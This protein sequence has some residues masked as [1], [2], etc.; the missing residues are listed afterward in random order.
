MNA[1]ALKIFV[2][3]AG[4]QLSTALEERAEQHGT[5]VALLGYP[6]LDLSASP[7]L[8]ETQIFKAVSAFGAQILV[9]AAAYTAVDK[10]EDEPELAQAINGVAPG[11]IAQV[12]ARLSIPCI[13]VSTDYVFDGTAE[14]YRKEDDPTSPLGVYGQT[15]LS[16][17][18]AVAAATTDHAILRTAWV[19]APFGANFVKTMLRL[20]SEGR[21]EL[22]VVAD[23]YGCPTSVLDIA[24]AIF[25]VASNLN[26]KPDDA[27][28]RGI[29]HLVGAGEANWAEFARAIFAGAT[30]RGAP[31]AAVKDLTSAE[32]PTK[33]KRP[34]NSRL[35][36]SKIKHIHNVTMPDWKLSLDIVLDRL[37]GS[38]KSA[39]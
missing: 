24:D 37:I 26:A 11:I 1:H 16:G 25:K 32:Y 10:A 34:F 19:Y 38:K 21:T 27:T 18:M 4:G 9:N 2:I 13:H 22:G 23:Q 39:S 28:L 5:T 33:A 3:G 12:A 6:E 35:D 17:E 29:F 30:L 20:A 31:S 8:V 36:T 14:G 15:K 7:E